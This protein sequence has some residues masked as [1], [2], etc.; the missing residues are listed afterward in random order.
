MFHGILGER[1]APAL[2]CFGLSFSLA[3]QKVESDVAAFF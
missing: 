1:K 2:R 3:S